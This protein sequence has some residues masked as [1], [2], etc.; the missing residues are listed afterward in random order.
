[1]A[2]L[3]ENQVQRLITLVAWMS[4]RDRGEPVSYETAGRRLGVPASVIESDLD[5]L[6]GLTDGIS[7]SLAS[8]QVAITGKGFLVGSLGAFRR[9]L[10]LTGDE[11]L[12]VLLGLLQGRD[13]KAL[14]ARLGALLDEAPS[15]DSV[16][17]AWAVGPTPGEGVSRVLALARRARDERRKLSILYCGSIGEPTRRVVHPHQVVEAG[18]A[19]YVV[20][21][22]ETAGAAR[23]FRAERVLEAELLTDEFE[24]TESLTRVRRPRDLLYAEG[25]GMATVAFSSRIA[26]WLRERYP[27][28]EA[29]PDGRYIVRFTVADPR[30]L[31]R[32]VLQYGAEA[33]VLEPAALREF[34]R[35]VVAAS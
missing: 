4:Q 9:P 7:S 11:S 14:A 12:A 17:R 19:W 28:G 15:V 27:D 8:L 34:V 3:A 13:G 25:V 30:W 21:W 10:R 22:C 1:M 33:E 20:A 31:A 2:D 29:R 18:G 6:L 16:D 26:R 23:R 35:G 5:V 24:P 32:E